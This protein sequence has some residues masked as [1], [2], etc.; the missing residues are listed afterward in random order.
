MNKKF[1][2]L[3]V[4]ELKYIRRELEYHIKRTDTLESIVRS[5]WFKAAVGLTVLGSAAN[6]LEHLLR[7]VP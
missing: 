5:V 6:A 3:I 1:K 4:K 7:L 2:K